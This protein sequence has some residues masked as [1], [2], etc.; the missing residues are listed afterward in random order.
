MARVPFC[1]NSAE[2]VRRCEAL[3]NLETWSAEEELEIAAGLEKEFDFELYLSLL[4]DR[5]P[6]HE[7]ARLRM[8][9][10]LFR[11]AKRAR[12][13]LTSASREVRVAWEGVFFSS[14]RLWASLVSEEDLGLAVEFLRDEDSSL[15]QGTA[16]AAVA[17][18]YTVP[19][20]PRNTPRTKLLA[21]RLNAVGQLRLR[22]PPAKI[23]EAVDLL[24]I[25]CAA[26]AVGASVAQKILPHLQT[27]GYLRRVAEDYVE[28][29]RLE[30]W[31]TL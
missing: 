8:S 6:C 2:K 22:S 24:E 30:R 11:L 7:E 28:A 19:G 12:P 18:V 21:E 1:F 14:M 16:A 26:H 23:S 13:Y 10:S 4:E 3:L 15:V 5:A 27:N 25:F 31:P 17:Q 9:A 20:T 29:L